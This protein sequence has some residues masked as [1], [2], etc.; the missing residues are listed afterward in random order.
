M[1]RKDALDINTILEGVAIFIV[2]SYILFSGGVFEAS[3][4]KQLVDMYTRP[5]WRMLVLGLV[6]IG[7]SWSP[8]VGLIT[9]LAV[10][11][12][13]NDMDILTSPFLSK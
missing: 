8:R 4:P 1:A 2:F 3:Y 9:A 13:L 6:V 5:W 7:A 11:L 12:Y 10:F